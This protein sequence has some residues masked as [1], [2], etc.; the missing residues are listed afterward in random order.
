LSEFF[1]LALEKCSKRDVFGGTN[2]GR[3]MKLISVKLNS[4]CKLFYV[5][6]EISAKFFYF[7]VLVFYFKELKRNFLLATKLSNLAGKSFFIKNEENI[8][9]KFFFFRLR[10][11]H[12]KTFDNNA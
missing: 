10:S 4:K 12:S 2:H 11:S 3:P 5:W 9:K 1:P 8:W 6:P 7:Y